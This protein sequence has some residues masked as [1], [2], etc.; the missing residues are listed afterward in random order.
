MYKIALVLEFVSF[1]GIPYNAEYTVDLGHV[2]L[3]YIKLVYCHISLNLY[4]HLHIHL[5][6]ERIYSELEMILRMEIP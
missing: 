4:I 1:L 6:F 3:S 5:D 2:S